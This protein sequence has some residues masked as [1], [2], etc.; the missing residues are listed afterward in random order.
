M[1]LEAVRA[2][3]TAHTTIACAAEYIEDAANLAY[4]P[5]DLVLFGQPI[6]IGS[7]ERF[8]IFGKGLYPFDI[9]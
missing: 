5:I 8:N 4:L 1:Q 9:D 2:A 6:S 7:E 3:K